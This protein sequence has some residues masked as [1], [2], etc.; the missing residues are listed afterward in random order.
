MKTS[1]YVSTDQIQALGYVGSSVKQ[2]VTYAIPEGT[3]YNGTITDS[4]FLTECLAQMKKGNP[5]LFK[6]D[7]SL[8]VDGG[9]I[10]ARRIATPKLSNKRYV[11]L[12]RDD[13]ADSIGDPNDL[14]CGYRKLETSENAIL[15]CAVGKTQVDSYISTF[16]DAG[17]K[18]ESIHIGAELILSFVKAKPELQRSTIVINVVDGNTMLS[19][20]FENGVSIFMSRTRL[21]GDIKEQVIQSMLENLNGLIQFTRSQKFNEISTCYYL[22]VTENDLRLLQAYN[23]HGEISIST[24]SICETTEDIPPDAHFASL[25]MMYGAK[26]V[27]LVVARKDLDKFIKS[28]KPKKLWI[29][30]LAVYVLILA[31]AAVYLLMQVRKADDEIAA[32]N[33]YI[34][35]PT[36]VAKMAEINAMNAE[37]SFYLD[38]EN[39]MNAKTDWEN[40]MP[41]ATAN[42][43]DLIIY[44]H[45][46]AVSVSSLEFNESSG[47]VKVNASCAG[48]NIAADYVNA[49]YD[50][51]VALNVEYTGYGS[52]AGGTYSFSV[53]ITLN[54]EEVVSNAN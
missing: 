37:T 52:S 9:S 54:P 21:Y 8:V 35:S 23:P 24:L 40:S 25:N 47:V 6:S 5:D 1:I 29:P 22:G 17:V 44:K 41:K 18:L 48:A 2:Y 33:S 4:S 19:L 27:D 43:L 30:A 28:K 38:I 26:G 39:Q 34:N 42:M 15:A 49:L 11:Q 32:L 3:M 46:V 53:N 12:I 20:L 51:G 16:K 31:A 36:V 10:L 7:V 14:V 45:G 13:F 50:C